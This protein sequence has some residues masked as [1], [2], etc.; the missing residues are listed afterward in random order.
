MLF[1][2]G[3]GRAVTA[4]AN[5]L[6]PGTGYDDVKSAAEAD[7]GQP[8][9][10]EI[11][12]G[13]TRT[14]EKE[15]AD[16]EVSVYLNSES[17]DMVSVDVYDSDQPAGRLILKPRTFASYTVSGLKG[18]CRLVISASAPTKALIY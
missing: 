17:S 6:K 13:E 7:G 16:G 1:S 15:P 4:K 18:L 10:I 2:D 11:G 8:D 9:E 5:R 14:V 3:D 12:A